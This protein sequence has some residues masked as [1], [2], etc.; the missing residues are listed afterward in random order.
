MRRNATTARATRETRI[1]MKPPVDPCAPVRTGG[2]G[3]SAHFLI[4]LLASPRNRRARVR[5]SGAPSATQ[6]LGD[7]AQVRHEPAALALARL[8]VG[9]PE[10]RA[11][12]DG[13]A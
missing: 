7:G 10:N 2:A 1:W 3:R 13:R 6:R 8:L 12:V 5:A 9:R 4:P 11:R